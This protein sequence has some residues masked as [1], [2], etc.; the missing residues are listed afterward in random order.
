MQWAGAAVNFRYGRNRN[1]DLGPHSNC[2]IL[3]SDIFAT[4]MQPRAHWD[5][6]CKEPLSQDN[7]CHWDGIIVVNLPTINWSRR[8]TH[9]AKAYLTDSSV[10]W[11]HEDAFEVIKDAL[12]N[13]L[14]WVA[15]LQLELPFEE[16]LCIAKTILF[17]KV[18]SH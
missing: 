4:A 14:A 17:D 1:P 16:C 12:H 6:K 10:D 9:Q 18:R 15:S 7:A 8:G 11:T 13:F 2:D 5:P 3:E